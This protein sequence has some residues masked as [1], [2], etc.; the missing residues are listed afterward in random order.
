M[1]SILYFLNRVFEPY[2]LKAIGQ[3]I[4][5]GAC[6][7]LV[8]QPLVAAYKF[9]SVPGRLGKVNRVR[10]WATIGILAVVLAAVLFVPLPSHIFCNLEV[11]A[12]DAAW[13]YVEVPGTLEEVYVKPGDHVEKGQ[14]LAQLA[15]PDIDVKIADLTGQREHDKRSSTSA[16]DASA[17]KS[18]DGRPDRAGEGGAGERRAAIGCSGNSIRRSWS[19][20]RRSRGPCCRRRLVPEQTQAEAQLPTWSG[21]PLEKENLGATMMVGSKLCQIGDPHRLEARLMIDQGDVELIAPGQRVD[22]MLT[23]AA[24]YCLRE[25]D[26]KGVDRES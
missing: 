12:R 22:V 8:V 16:G 2:G 10:M 25:P 21:S 19:W 9:F 4:A 23:Q 14:K 11:Q 26:R 15:N 5:M 3:L 6:Y 18:S 17:L 1:L 7:G 20:L 24:G 13:V